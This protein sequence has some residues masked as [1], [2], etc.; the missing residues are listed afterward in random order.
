[1]R[2][3]ELTE[4]LHAIRRQDNPDGDFCVVS[5]SVVSRREHRRLW[6]A[7]VWDD[8]I[9]DRRSRICIRHGRTG[10]LRRDR[11]QLATD[12]VSR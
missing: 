1:M 5:W 7:A 9:S 8:T 2:S 11:T 4:E 3:R 6:A 12:D 10:D